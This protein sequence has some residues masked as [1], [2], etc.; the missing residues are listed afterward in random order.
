MCRRRLASSGSSNRPTRP[1]PPPS[2]RSS[3]AMHGGS[4]AGGEDTIDHERSIGRN[5]DDRQALTFI[6]DVLDRLLDGSPVVSPHERERR[7]ARSIDGLATP[8]P[9]IDVEQVD[10][11]WT[12]VVASGVVDPSARC[13]LWSSPSVTAGSWPTNSSHLS[14]TGPSAP[15][16]LHWPISNRTTPLCR[17][18]AGCR[19]RRMV[20]AGPVPCCVRLTCES[21]R[22]RPST[23]RLR[24]TKARVI[25]RGAP[26]SPTTKEFFE[27]FLP[28]IGLAFEPD[29]LTVF[30]R[31]EVLY[32]E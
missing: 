25:A 1:T 5:L 3:P 13:H 23:R 29:M 16:L 19:S 7:V 6:R 2:D 17:F 12:R 32:S 31:F 21:G 14:S 24:G 26:G 4:R 20:K 10:E 9:P 11:F 28:T 22:C 15:Q 8:L 18:Q 27:R 30:E